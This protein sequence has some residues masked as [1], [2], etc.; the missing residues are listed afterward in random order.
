MAGT[1]TALLRLIRSH[2]AR[3]RE[4]QDRT[5]PEVGAQRQEADRAPLRV[6]QDFVQRDLSFPKKKKLTETE[7]PDLKKDRA[8]KGDE[9]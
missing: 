4:G 8:G 1:E 2:A 9:H 5:T 3:K 6:L 7:R